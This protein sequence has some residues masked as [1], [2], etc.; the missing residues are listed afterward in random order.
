MSTALRTVLWKKLNRPTCML[1]AGAKGK[2]TLCLQQQKSG[3]PKAVT[4][5]FAQY[6][7]P[8][9]LRDLQ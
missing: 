6:T 7:D 5:G 1:H 8:V 3:S 2:A 9:V 4:E